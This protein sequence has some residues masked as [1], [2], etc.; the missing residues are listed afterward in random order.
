MGVE[1]KWLRS[2]IRLSVGKD[3]TT[4]D[5]EHAVSQIR[6]AVTTSRGD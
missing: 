3:N 6:D 4:E 1:E 5:I 2:S